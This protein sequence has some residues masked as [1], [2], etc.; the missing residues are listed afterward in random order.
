M[1]RPAW[2][3]DLPGVMNR[4]RLGVMNTEKLVRTTFV[5][6]RETSDRISYIA[7]RFQRSRSDVVRELL[8]EPI[9]VMDNLCRMVPENPS[10]A[11]LHQM[12]L[13][14]LEAVD[15]V[16]ERDVAPLRRL[17]SE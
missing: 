13:A 5:L 7:R 10:A 9:Q 3:A 12:V 11:E 6:E 4:R 14:G 2:I 8:A 15:A 16:A 17:V 1:G